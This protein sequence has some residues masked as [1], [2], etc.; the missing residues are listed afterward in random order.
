MAV[1]TQNLQNAQAGLAEKAATDE[2]SRIARELHD[3]IAHSMSVTMLHI[4]AARMALERDR[5]S[6]AL[7]ALQ[8]AE[9]Q[10]RASLNDVR[11]TVGLLGQDDGAVA[12]PAPGVGDLPKLVGDF[13]AAGLDVGLHISGEVGEIPAATG[14][15]LYRIVQESLTNI[16]KHAPGASATVDL[17]LTGTIRLVISNTPV[18]GTPAAPAEGGGLGIRGMVE[19]ATSLGGQ[20]HAGPA[21]DGWAVELVAPLVP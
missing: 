12:P 5:A 6:D 19:R 20:L 2:R 14:L 10:G 7:D 17:D 11:R 18:N 16:A 13:R 8:E 21:G 1:L 15:S 3:V 9:R 4:T